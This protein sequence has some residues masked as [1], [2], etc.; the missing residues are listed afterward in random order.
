MKEFNG[1]RILGIVITLIVFTCLLY[2]WALNGQEIIRK[3][4]M[5]QYP[6]RSETSSLGNDNNPKFDSCMGSFQRFLIIKN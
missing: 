3:Y 2:I 6:I 5:G 1:Y 4:C